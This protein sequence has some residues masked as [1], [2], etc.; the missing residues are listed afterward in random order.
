[1]KEGARDRRR[2]DVR[3]PG[4]KSNEPGG[5]EKA[6][7]GASSLEKRTEELR[8]RP[9]VE[10]GKEDGPAGNT[11]GAEAVQDYG[12]IAPV[13]GDP[14]LDPV[15]TPFDVARMAGYGSGSFDALE[16][17]DKM[18]MGEVDATREMHVDS[19]TDG[20]PMQ[21]GP[22]ETIFSD[23]AGFGDMNLGLTA[24]EDPSNRDWCKELRFGG[25]D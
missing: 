2:D 25:A 5:R 10:D 4:E 6:P 24:E 11:D 9:T 18:V 19:E 17:V 3:R 7:D 13:H 8:G 23:D 14:S 1:M 21:M 12:T 22:L 15:T 16:G 20:G